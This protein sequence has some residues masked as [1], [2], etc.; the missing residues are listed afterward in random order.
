MNT[1][2]LAIAA[3]NGFL[4]VAAGAFGAHA[5]KGTLD[6]DAM[7][8]FDVGVRYQRYQAVELLA[9]ASVCHSRPS[10]AVRAAGICML[11]GIVLFTGSLYGLTLLNWRWLG[12]VTPIGGVF[13]LIGWFLLAVSGWSHAPSAG[14]IDSKRS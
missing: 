5:L 7:N 1:K 13:F 3:I 2:W 14:A 12:P 9:V 4:A 6:A 8:A 10:R 11:I